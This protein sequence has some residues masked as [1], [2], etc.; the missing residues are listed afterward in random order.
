MTTTT[1][2]RPATHEPFGERLRQWRE[3]RRVSQLELALRA[4]TT[5]RHLSFIERG[6]SVPGR[7]MVIRLAES[8]DLA[9]RERNQLLL[10][11]GYAPAYPES[12]LDDRDLHAVRDALSAIL[13]GHE[14]YPAMIVNRAGELLLANK[15]CALFFEGLPPHLLEAP[16]NTRRIALHPEGL[17]ARIANFD[18]WAPHVTES[19]RRELTRNPDPRLQSLLEE[20]ERYVPDRPVPA[21]HLGFAVPLD[22]STPQGPVRL[23]TTLTTF[24]TATDVFLAELRMEAF[25]PADETTAQ[26]LRQR[27]AMTPMPQPANGDQPP[28]RP[29]R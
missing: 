24:A 5:Q 25:L 19:L 9:L 12:T 20:L 22:L 28:Q 29:V 6:R 26:R 23:I 18:T 27:A 2:E 8:L 14:P 3:V 11:A 10:H 21:D 1:S 15:A 17:A 16:V 4:G 13:T 7:A